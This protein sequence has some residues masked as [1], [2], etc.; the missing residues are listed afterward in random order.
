M[1]IYLHL[2]ISESERGIHNLM[3]RILMSRSIANTVR[4]KKGTREINPRTFA[5][6]EDELSLVEGGEWLPNRFIMPESRGDHN[7]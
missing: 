5:C 4:T 2:Y 3:G 1:F 7:L 6:I